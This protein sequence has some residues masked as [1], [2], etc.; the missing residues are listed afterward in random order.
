MPIS[1]DDLRSDREFTKELIADSEADLKQ[2]EIP[3]DRVHL[4]QNSLGGDYR[5][6]GIIASL[7]SEEAKAR[8]QF[9]EAT[10]HYLSGV[11]TAR[12]RQDEISKGDW[13]S[14]PSILLD[15]LYSGILSSD[16]ELLTEVARETLAMDSEYVTEFPETVYKYH[17]AK[18]LASVVFDAEETQTHLDSLRDA[19]DGLR[20]ELAQFFGAIATVA[21][22]IVGTHGDTVA[23]GVQELLDHHSSTFEGKPTRT[24]QAVSVP[25]TALVSLARR[26]GIDVTV[27]SEYLLSSNGRID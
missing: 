9:A 7:L 15:A 23:E 21:E 6:L 3:R 5:D 14:E 10:D 19:L 27:E 4:V 26:K 8:E 2:G 20:P 24:G 13:E 18:A 17:A 11:R 1:E 25:A 22:G 12:E 16:D